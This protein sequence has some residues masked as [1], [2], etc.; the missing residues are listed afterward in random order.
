M[1]VWERRAGV[2]QVGRG[3]FVASGGRVES[4]RAFRRWNRNLAAAVQNFNTRL[5][6][7]QVHLT[8]IIDRFVTVETQAPA[9]L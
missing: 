8:N 6:A 2:L 3:H 5:G 1:C 7:G 9:A 4:V